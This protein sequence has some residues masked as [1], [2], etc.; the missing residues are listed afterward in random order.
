MCKEIIKKRTL[1]DCYTK[2]EHAWLEP[3]VLFKQQK[4]NR[5]MMGHAGK[6]RNKK[7][8]TNK[9]RNCS[10]FKKMKEKESKRKHNCR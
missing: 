6:K 9:P 4:K 1:K 7:I 3:P 5:K 2:R 10:L 8:K